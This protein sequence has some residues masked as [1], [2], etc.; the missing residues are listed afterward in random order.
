MFWMLRKKGRYS[1]EYEA[2][3]GKTRPHSVTFC[4]NEINVLKL[5]KQH[6]SDEKFGEKLPENFSERACI[7]QA[8]PILYK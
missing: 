3:G 5:E 4:H 1:A 7:L 8:R 2:A 6:K